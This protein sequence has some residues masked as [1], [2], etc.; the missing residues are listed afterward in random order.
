MKNSV[1]QFEIRVRKSDERGD[2]KNDW[3]MSKHTFSF[4]EYFD[5]YFMGYRS[6]RV[7]NEDWIQ[8]Q[9]GFQT[10]PHHD[11]EILTY[12]LEGELR[13]RDSMGN[14]GVIRAGE[15]QRMTA[16]TGV[17]HS[18][19]NPSQKQALHLIQIW[20][21]P[22]QFSLSPSYEQKAFLPSEGG[23]CL[24]LVASLD[25]REGSLKIHQQTT[26]YLGKLV[27]NQSHQMQRVKG[28]YLWIQMIRGSLSVNDASL[29]AG[30]GAS[31][32]GEG[33]LEFYN[34]SSR[35]ESQFLLFDLEV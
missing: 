25:G 12:V 18:E 4:G 13:H 28:Q 15:F 34:L 3:L 7:I 33:V 1:V 21:H 8:P 27:Q 20:I 29:S 23:E 10:H 2:F 22:N 16:G 14:D 17:F 19:V 26:L 32:E 6:L 30:D 11:M 31:I 5:P 9:S 35:E 24:R